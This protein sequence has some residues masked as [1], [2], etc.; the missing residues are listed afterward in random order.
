VAFTELRATAIIGLLDALDIDRCTLVG[1]SMGGMIS[2]TVALRAPE[3]V[4]RI[5][6]MGSGGAPVPPTPELVEMIRFY[7]DPTADAMAG[8]MRNF[9][10]DPAMF[11]DELDA[12]AA[13]RLTRAVRDDVRRSHL[14]TFDMAAGPPVRF[15]PDQLATLAQPALVIHGREDRLIPHQAAFYLLE[16]LPDADLHIFARCGHW[17]QIEHPDRF[18]ATLA[19]FLDTRSNP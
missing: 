6:L 10:Y 18:H 15:E 2:V 11:G 1:N 19:A 14:A 7:E 8:L 16:H 17:T 12:I 3:R 13:A 9:V 4:S 5:V